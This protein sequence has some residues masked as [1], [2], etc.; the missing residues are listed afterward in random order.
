MWIWCS[1]NP[2]LAFIIVLVVIA[3]IESIASQ[4]FKNKKKDK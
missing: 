4:A 2:F 1:E 3:A